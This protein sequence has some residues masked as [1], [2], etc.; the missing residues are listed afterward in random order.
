[1]APLVTSQPI[2]VAVINSSED[3]TDLLRL[4]FEHAGFVVVTA[5]THAIR[6]HEVDFGALVRL[7][8]PDVIVY[9]VALPYDANWRLFVHLRDSPACDGTRFVITT[10]NVA[11]VRKA[12]GTEEVMHEIV[13]K[14]YDLNL[15]IDAVREAANA[16]RAARRD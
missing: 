12:V 15:L 13:G 16:S 3:T 2:V 7:H 14:P 10:T 8:R 1:M 5:F 4:A 6:D 9:D 11:Q